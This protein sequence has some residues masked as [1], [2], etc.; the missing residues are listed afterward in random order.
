M[1]GYAWGGR[2]VPR[3]GQPRCR[4]DT[5]WTSSSSLRSPGAPSG[6]RRLSPHFVDGAAARPQGESRTGKLVASGALGRPPPVHSRPPTTNQ[7][8]VL[9]GGGAS[10]LATP[11][12][13]PGSLG[14]DRRAY[15]RTREDRKD[16]DKKCP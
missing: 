3:Q 13:T 4:S 1:T 8:A 2:G 9:Q 14:E 12:P 6:Y 16:L 5:S 11:T 7:V 10:T 15:G